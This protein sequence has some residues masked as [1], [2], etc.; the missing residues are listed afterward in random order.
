MK[1]IPQVNNQSFQWD[2]LWWEKDEFVAFNHI[3]DRPWF[4]RRWVIQEAAYSTNSVVFCGD[5]LV[6]LDDFTCAVRLVRQ[7][8]HDIPLSVDEVKGYSNDFLANFHDSPATRLLD[9]IGTAFHRSVEGTMLRNRRRLSLEML[10]DLS[11]FCETKKPHFL[12]C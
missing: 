10:V 5:R 3:L 4:R 1:L 7:R 9:I 8:L 11:S 6:K 12:L 2:G